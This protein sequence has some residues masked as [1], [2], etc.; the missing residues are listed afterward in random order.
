MSCKEDIATHYT[1]D[2]SKLG[3]TKTLISLLEDLLTQKAI[4]ADLRKKQNIF[5][6]RAQAAKEA[7]EADATAKVQTAKDVYDEALAKNDAKS[8]EVLAA[9]EAYD[10]A[11]A[12]AN[13]MGITLEKLEVF[14]PGI[15]EHGRQAMSYEQGTTSGIARD[16]MAKIEQEL[17]KVIVVLEKR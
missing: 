13:P 14:D 8:I 3:D 10:K 5:Q 15:K 16:C 6:T 1:I 4:A 9:K 7:Y 17:E 11:V 2:S 12:D